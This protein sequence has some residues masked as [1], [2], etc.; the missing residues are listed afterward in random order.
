MKHK[1]FHR[2][3]VSELLAVTVPLMVSWLSTTLMLFG[4][5]LL[6]AHYS[7]DALAAAINGGTMAW[8]FAY[9]AQV[10]TEMGQVVVGQYNGAKQYHKLSA[11]PWQMIWLALASTLL[12]FPLSLWGSGVIFSEASASHTYFAWL[13][14][15]GPVFALIGAGSAY[16]AGQGQTRRI[17]VAALIGN[18]TNLLLDW[19]LIFGVEGVIS[20]MG[21]KGAAIATGIGMSMQA[22]IL[23][24]PFFWREGV[25]ESRIR[26]RE[27]RP[28]LRVGFPPGVFM[29][30]E[31]V[32]WGCFFS[33]MA[34][35]SQEHVLV[36]SMCQMLLP[37]LATPG[38]SLQKGIS[39]IGGN[40]IGAGRGDSLGSLLRSGV[41]VL[42]SYML[43]LFS[44]E[45]LLGGP[46]LS[47]VSG[48]DGA[49]GCTTPYPIH[50]AAPL[51]AVPTFRRA[52]LPGGWAAFC[53]RGIVPS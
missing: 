28:C 26:W 22:A 48:G 18:G 12:F 1:E 50:R 24:V 43:M 37:L 34:R 10:C 32:G 45:A 30:V 44:V 4:D 38:I 46:I 7:L 11:P 3:N 16:F 23:I 39:A 9:G 31:L 47:L 51:D 53:S 2:G 29:G 42:L 20:P 6:L 33:L 13:V 19:L 40:L 41:G 49:G 25:A 14:A 8:G 21:E 17:T 36:T 35:A 5:R 52:A 15:F 27:M